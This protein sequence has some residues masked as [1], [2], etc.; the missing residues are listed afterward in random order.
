MAERRE[1]SHRFLYGLAGVTGFLSISQETLWIKV[2]GSAN[3]NRPET[4]AHAL[5][6]FL[7]GLALGA[8][9][10]RPL[11]ARL[12]LGNLRFV[13]VMVAASGIVFYLA[14]PLGAEVLVHDAAWGRGVLFVATALTAAGMGVVL[15]LLC[16]A[17]S[18]DGTPAGAATSR[19][20]LANVLGAA[21]GPLVTGYVMLEVETLEHNILF[22][23]IAALG[24]AQALWLRAPERRRR[25]GVGI[26]ALASLALLATHKA[27][28]TLFLEK[29]HFGDEGYEPGYLYVAQGRAGIVGVWPGGREYGEGLY[30]GGFNLDP[31]SNTNLINRAYFV[32]ALHRA[33]H[34]ILEIGLGTGSWA[35]ILADNPAVDSLTIVEID[36]AYVNVMWHYPEIASVLDDPRVRLHFDDGRRWLARNPA[37]RFDVIV[38]NGTWHWRSGATHIL[39]AEFLAVLRAHLAPGGVAY[40]NT[41]G[42]LDVMYTAAGAFRHV[43]RVSNFVAASDAPFDQRD[44]ERRAAMLRILAPDGKPRIRGDSAAVTLDRFLSV[45]SGDLAPQLR[46]ANDLWNITDDNMATEFKANGAGLWWRDLPARVWRPDRAWPTILF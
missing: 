13:A 17:V 10:R 5:G 6:F 38:I 39:S 18:A 45:A 11:Q 46:R 35:R 9:G 36:P 29:V 33:P 7:L 4:F 40:F 30:D 8:V 42:S 22:V 28:F 37:R 3:D 16:E 21:A 14:M 44:D 19:V 43:M 26:F 1:P 24:I 31:V 20:L 32:P 41:T 15:P 2:I 12:G 23:A 27:A 34:R 25:T